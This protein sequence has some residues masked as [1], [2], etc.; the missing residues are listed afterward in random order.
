MMLL[1]VVTQAFKATN[2]ISGREHEFR[3]GDTFECYS[4]QPG[5]EV[6]IEFEDSLVLVELSALKSCCRWKNEGM[7]L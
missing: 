4:P 2:P 1:C 3:P 6:T 7:P 5:N